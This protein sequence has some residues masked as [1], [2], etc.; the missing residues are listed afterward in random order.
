MCWVALAACQTPVPSAVDAGDDAGQPFAVDAGDGGA[1]F[2]GGG[3]AGACSPTFAWARGGSLQGTLQQAIR[4]VDVG[5]DGSIVI[6]GN[7]SGSRS[8][9]G[10]PL[11]SVGGEDAFVMM[12]EADGTVRWS[13]TFG[14]SGSDVAIDCDVSPMGSVVVTGLF[15]R[16]VTFGPGVEATS[17]GAVDVFTL[18][19]SPSG[20]PV[21]VRSAGGAGSDYGNEIAVDRDGNVIV[22]LM[23]D[24]DD[25]SFSG[26]AAGAVPRRGRND[27]LVVSYATD[28]ALRWWG[29]VVGDGDDLGRGVA[30]DEAGNVIF[31]GETTSAIMEGQGL[32]VGTAAGGSDLFVTSW[33]STG[34]MRW[35][36]RRGGPL[37]DSARAA[38]GGPDGTVFV[39]GRFTGTVDFGGVTRS[40]ADGTPDLFVA[41]LGPAAA[42]EWVRSISS[43]GT[44]EGVELSVSRRGEII[45]SGDF[46]SDARIE[47]RTGAFVLSAA[48]AQTQTLVANWALDG[49]LRWAVAGGGPG[50]EV[51]YD[52]GVS[53][54]G[55]VVIVGTSQGEATFGRHMLSSQD[56][57]YI[58][59]LAPCR[60]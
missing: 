9:A 21:W 25:F 27:T 57:V 38:G 8:V 43:T 56:R 47:G 49:E 23:Y 39:G 12:L 24:S 2:D 17:V 33:T 4:G 44:E 18:M 14:A 19:L 7:T 42:V 48:S 52:V 28:G 22:A 41:R 16:R 3:D 59:A 30:T 40:S 36:A 10:Q 1:V 46:S 6:C 31:V 50:R 53:A 37:D 55:A 34:Q 26:Q 5:S 51:N 35:S 54:Q 13:R 58:A 29:A 20:E 60:P 45:V 11:T 32:A 15:Q